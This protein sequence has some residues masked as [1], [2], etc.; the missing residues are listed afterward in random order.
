MQ[1]HP[2][3][4]YTLSYEKS[5]NV[6]PWMVI[7]GLDGFYRKG[8]KKKQ[9]NHDEWGIASPNKLRQRFI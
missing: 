2:T 4:R 9:L 6:K 3:I 5:S 7:T 1:I 8:R